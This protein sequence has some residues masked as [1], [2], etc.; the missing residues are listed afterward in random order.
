MMNFNEYYSPNFKKYEFFIGEVNRNGYLSLPIKQ[1]EQID[2]YYIELCK[3]LEIVRARF[4]NRPIT[5]T[6]GYRH[7]DP[8]FHGKGIAADYNVKGIHPYTVAQA[9]WSS[10]PGGLGKYNAHVHMDVRYLVGYPPG[11]WEGV[12]R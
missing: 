6:S 7:K 3:H 9:Y 11:R 12:S 10:Y 1:Q 5:I 2:K 8:L 4:G